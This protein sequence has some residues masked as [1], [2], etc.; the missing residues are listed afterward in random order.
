MEV[1]IVFEKHFYGFRSLELLI[2]VI[3]T[4]LISAREAHQTVCD[5]FSLVREAVL[6]C[7]TLLGFYDLLPLKISFK[8]VN[9]SSRHS[10]V[11][12]SFLFFF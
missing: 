12:L 11:I 3:Q 10:T 1:H 5:N 6:T 4:S 7:M 2:Y 9:F 8:N